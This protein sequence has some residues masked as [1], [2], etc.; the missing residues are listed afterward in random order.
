MDIQ[1]GEPVFQ[2]DTSTFI[3]YTNILTNDH[4]NGYPLFEW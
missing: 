2:S 3:Y 1:V 4:S